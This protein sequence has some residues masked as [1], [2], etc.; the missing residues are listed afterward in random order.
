MFYV[1]VSPAA[2]CIIP[3]MLHRHKDSIDEP[4]PKINSSGVFILKTFLDSGGGS[5]L[6]RQESSKAGIVTR[7]SRVAMLLRCSSFSKKTR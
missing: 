3:Q 7:F 2:E 4:A 1:V 5:S 6:K